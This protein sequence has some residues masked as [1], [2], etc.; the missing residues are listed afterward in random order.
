MAIY[1]PKQGHP[2]GL[3]HDKITDN[4]KTD[5]CVCLMVQWWVR[6]FALY[7]N[8]PSQDCVSRYVCMCIVLDVHRD[9][10]E[11]SIFLN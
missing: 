5:D 11:Q 9:T 4:L 1:D 2:L 3:V 7:V 6:S 10:R 8:E